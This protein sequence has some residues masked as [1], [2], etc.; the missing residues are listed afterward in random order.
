MRIYAITRS[1]TLTGPSSQLLRY[2][3]D[4]GDSLNG[5]FAVRPKPERSL[6]DVATKLEFRDKYSY[7]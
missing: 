5:A 6:L 1:L 4:E 3:N 2:A 7:P